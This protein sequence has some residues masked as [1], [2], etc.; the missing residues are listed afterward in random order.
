MTVSQQRGLAQ[1]WW[2][3]LGQD[4]AVL[5][6]C[7]VLLELFKLTPVMH[8]DTRSLPYGK[9]RLLEMAIALA[10]EPKVLL[11]DEPMAGVPAAERAELMQT[12]STLPDDVTVLLIEHDMDLVFEFAQRI[13]VLVNGAVLVQGTPAEIARNEQVKAVYLGSQEVNA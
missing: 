7:E 10:C 12:L 13:T 11:L 8:Q 2:T 5:K 3:P 1:Q 4:A 9:R 6:R